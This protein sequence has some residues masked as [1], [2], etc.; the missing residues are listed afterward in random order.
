MRYKRVLI[1]TDGSKYSR[2][3]LYYG[4]ELAGELKSTLVLLHVIPETAGSEGENNA[5]RILLEHGT[6]VMREGVNLEKRIMKGVPWEEIVKESARGYDMVIIGS[7]G[8][9]GIRRVLIGSVAENVTRYSRA[10]VVIV[11]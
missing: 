6:I 3:A 2:K 9:T 10:P 8:I 4:I 11:H 5:R 1:P 7:K